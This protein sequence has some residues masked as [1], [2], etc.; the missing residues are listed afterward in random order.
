[1]T[2]L[3]ALVL[4]SGERDR[5]V[6]V[7]RVVFAMDWSGEEEPGDLAAFAAGRLRAFGADPTGLDTAPVYGAAETDP[8]LSRGDLPTRLLDHVAAALTEAGCTLLLRHS[9]TDSYEVLVAPTTQ[10]AWTDLTHEGCPVRPWGSASEPTL[11]SLDCPACGDMLVWELP[12]GE[13]LA[14]EHCDC[15]TPLFDSTGHPL[16]NITLHA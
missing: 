3:A 5:G 1:M 4:T 11:T 6:P 10:F 13:T 15:G 14:D 12:P 2:E 16:P 9:G 7:D 8:A